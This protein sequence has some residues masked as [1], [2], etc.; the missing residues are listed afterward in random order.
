[1]SDAFSGKA[2]PKRSKPMMWVRPPDRPGP[3]NNFPD[4]AIRDGDWKLL[5]FRDGSRA[6]LFNMIDDP[7]EKKNL[8][9]EYP[10]VAKALS[11]QVIEWDAGVRAD[12]E[13]VAKQ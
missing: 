11:A 1:M 9:S 3:K 2:Q 13:N 12:V 8:A 6:E 5:V 7:N 4:L 10:E